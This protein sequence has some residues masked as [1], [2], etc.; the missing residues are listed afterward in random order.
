M[1]RAFGGAFN[2]SALHQTLDANDSY[3]AFGFNN[4]TDV[5]LLG[6][7]NRASRFFVASNVIF[8]IF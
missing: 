4:S 7:G 6:G 8:D 3:T 2:S 1:I 5:D